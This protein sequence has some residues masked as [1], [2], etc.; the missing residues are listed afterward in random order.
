MPVKG[1][2]HAFK[3]CIHRVSSRVISSRNLFI[4]SIAVTY[5]LMLATD[6]F[7]VMFRH[8]DKAL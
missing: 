4:D 7:T 1:T 6:I 8:I 2:C 5:R 3:L